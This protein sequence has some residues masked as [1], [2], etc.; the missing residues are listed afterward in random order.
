MNIQS[1]PMLERDKR[2]YNLYLAQMYAEL[3]STFIMSEQSE[4][5]RLDIKTEIEISEARIDAINNE[6]VFIMSKIQIESN[7]QHEAILLVAPIRCVYHVKDT[8]R[9]Q[10]TTTHKLENRRNSLCL[11]CQRYKSKAI[12]NHQFVTD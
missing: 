12:H 7:S 4:D 9:K 11:S 8:N 5:R 2:A 3:D 10:F 6:V 1:T